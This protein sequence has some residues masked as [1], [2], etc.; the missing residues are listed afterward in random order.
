MNNNYKD[1]FTKDNTITITGFRNNI[2]QILDKVHDCKQML[3]TKYGKPDM[4]LMDY[5]EYVRMINLVKYVKD[6]SDIEINKELI[7]KI[8]DFRGAIEYKGELKLPPLE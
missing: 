6:E 3:I 1:M 2:E 7:E 5:E 8:G 4:V